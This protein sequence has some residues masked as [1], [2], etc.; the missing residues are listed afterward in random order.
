L[1]Q[2]AARFFGQAFGDDDENA[3]GRNERL[4]ASHRCREKRFVA[5]AE[6]KKL[7]RTGCA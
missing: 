6:W 1:R 4:E 2:K 7:L 5:R 3:L